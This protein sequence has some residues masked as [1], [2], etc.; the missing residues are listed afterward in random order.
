M[1]GTIRSLRGNIH[2]TMIPGWRSEPKIR[3]E[4]WQEAKQALEFLYED[5][6]DSLGK[7]DSVSTEYVDRFYTIFA[8][9]PSV[10]ETPEWKALKAAVDEVDA[11]REQVQTGYIY[12]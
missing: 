6:K 8:E 1:S 5:F 12:T 2:I 10:M 3:P 9:F 7:P 11:R 4:K